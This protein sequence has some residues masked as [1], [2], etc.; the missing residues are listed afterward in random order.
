MGRDV[1]EGWD[2]QEVKQPLSP[3][4]ENKVT[5]NPEELFM[6]QKRGKRATGQRAI[7]RSEGRSG[8]GDFVN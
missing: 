4:L 3:S 1:R 2:T 8:G 7:R 6:M 5:E